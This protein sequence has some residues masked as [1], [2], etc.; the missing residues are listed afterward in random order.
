MLRIHTTGMAQETRAASARA[1]MSARTVATRSPYAAG[2]ANA[3]ESEGDATPGT[4][5]LSPIKRNVW[6]ITSGIRASVLG[7]IRR[8]GQTSTFVMTA[9]ATKLMTML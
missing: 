2:T 8:R 1:A 4:R 9:N 5:K 3:G 7:M 6:G